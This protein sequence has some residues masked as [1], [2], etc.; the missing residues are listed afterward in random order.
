[1]RNL[2][3]LF[4]FDAISLFIKVPLDE[5]MEAIADK[6]TQDKTLDER[7]TLSISEIC[8][9][10]NLCLRKTYFQFKDNFYEPLEGAARGITSLHGCC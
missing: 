4:N 3:K 7:T 8:R 1:M 6:L 2:T 10:T 9:L 5:A